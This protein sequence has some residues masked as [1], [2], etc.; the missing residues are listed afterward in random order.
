MGMNPLQK[1]SRIIRNR[2]YLHARRGVLRGF[3]SAPMPNG[4]HSQYGQDIFVSEYL[5]HRRNG[6]FVDVGASDGVTFSNTCHFE[7]V[8]GWRGL[9]I[10]PLPETFL[11]LKANRTCTPINAC[12]SGENA[13]VRFMALDGYTEML[14][15]IVSTFDARHR[16]RI[17]EELA[18]HGGAK[19][20]INVASFTLKSILEQH[21]VHEIDYLSVDTEGS[22]LAILRSI[23]FKTA[24]IRVISVENNY[25]DS[26]IWRLLTRQGYR[27]AAVLGCDEIYARTAQGLPGP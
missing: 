16:A 19:R 7:R 9:A 13:L 6:F 24:R 17:D 1:I 8:L 14:S 20:E 4:Y 18:S 2:L 12:I 5:G 15:G 11:K 25:V 26:D 22:E 23:D 21:N 3:E 27:L 10:E